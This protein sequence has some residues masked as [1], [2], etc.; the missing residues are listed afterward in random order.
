MLAGFVAGEKIS[1]N[2][3][4]DKDEVLRLCQIGGL[5]ELF[6]KTNIPHTHTK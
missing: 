6:S 2:L 4:M 5:T 3:G 1:K